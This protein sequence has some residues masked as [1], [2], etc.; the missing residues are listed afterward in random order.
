MRTKLFLFCLLLTTMA[1]A[2]IVYHDAS[3][4]PLLGKATEAT[5]TRYERLPDSLQHISRKPLWDLGRS[6][7]G[8]ALRFRSNSTCIAARWEVRDNR[9]MNHMTPTG[10]KG[11]DLYC[12][13]DGEWIFAGSGRPQGKVNKATIVGNMLPQERE[14][15][16]YL[17]LYDGVT[18]LAIGVD[19]LSEILQPAVDLPRR[20]KPIVFYGTSILQGGCASRPGMAHTNILERRLNRECINLGFSGNALLDLEIAHLMASVDASMFVLDF[21]PNAAVEQ[22]R[23]RADEF[24]SIIRRKHPDTPILFI[25]DPIFTHS[26]FD[27]RIAKEVKD[28]NETL[29]AIFQSL[30]QRGEKNIYFLS[31][32]DIIGHDGEATVDGIHFTDLG[33]MRYAEV[34][35]PILKKHIE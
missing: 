33:F 16:L 11:L 4:F 14:Y 7:A 29:N 9:S 17:S 24:Y 18:S 30:K 25:E 3:A 26:P 35:Y 34:L 13:Q 22:M 1:G 27:T 8:L 31:S 21:V 15:L 6:S 32:R 10:I 12:L 28:K 2:Q 5:A 23:E 19:S 20:E